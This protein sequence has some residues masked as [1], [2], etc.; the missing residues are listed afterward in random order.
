MTIADCGLQ[1][2]ALTIVIADC[3]LVFPVSWVLLAEKEPLN[4]PAGSIR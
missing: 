2:D 3:G 4:E 1:I